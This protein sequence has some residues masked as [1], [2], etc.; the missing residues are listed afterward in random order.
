MSKEIERSVE[1]VGGYMAD[2]AKQLMRIASPTDKEIA[3]KLMRALRDPS[4]VAAFIGL[5]NVARTA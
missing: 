1:V 3:E 4:K 2:Q 5:E